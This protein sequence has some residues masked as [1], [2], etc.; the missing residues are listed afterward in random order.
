MLMKLTKLSMAYP[1]HVIAYAVL[2]T[3][4]FASQFVKIK[5]DTD[6][7]NMLPETSSVRVYNTKVEETFELHPDVIVLGMTHG[8]SIFNEKTLHRLA[9]LTEKIKTID[10]VIPEDIISLAEASNVY[11]EGGALV[12]RPA[13]SE[14]SPDENRLKRLRASVTQN[15]LFSGKLVSRDGKTTVIYIPIVRKASGKKITD[16]ITKL[17]PKN[18]EERFY[19]A[20]DPVAR[21]T[22]GEDMFKQMAFFSPL[23]G[24]VMFIM[25]WLMFKNFTLIIVNMGVA[26]IS[27][28]WSMG[29]FI[30]AGV[31]VHIMSSM[32]PVFLMAI[33]TDTVHIFNEFYF[34]LRETKNKE[35][36]VLKTMEAVARPILFTDLT[37]MAGF[38]SLATGH[39]VP[40]KIFGLMI[41]AGTFVILL[42]SFTIVPAV[43][44]LIPER[45]L[46]HPE[47]EAHTGSRFLERL[48]SFSFAQKKGIALVSVILFV[49]SVFGMSKLHVNNNMLAWFK[50]GSTVRVADDVMNKTLSGTAFGYVVA[51]A[52]KEG[53]IKNPRALKEIELLQRDI[54]KIPD[55]G[56]TLSIVD[57]LKRIHRVLHGD[58]SAYEKIPDAQNIIA[59]YLFLFSMSAK[60]RDVNN[61]LEPSYREAAIFVQLETW[62]AD[63]YEKVVEKLKEHSGKN[64]STLSYK[65][66]GIAYFNMIWNKE[67]LYGMLHGFIMG[68]LF[69]FVLMA[70]SFRSVFWGAAASVPL[71]FTIALIYGFV[72]FVGKDFDMPI[73][74]LSTLSLG[75]ATDFAVHFVGRFQQKVNEGA[76]VKDALLWTVKRPG[77]GIVRNAI[78][79]SSGFLVMVFSPLTP[80]ITVG[81]FMA[82]IMLI[83]ALATLV[84]LPG[85][86]A[87]TQSAWNKKKM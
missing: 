41:A 20:G 85:I 34:R 28:I 63:A 54:E 64:A 5:T 72:G 50:K 59:Q 11:E 62:D 19:I 36:A 83:S 74:V 38:A 35:E 55:V 9:E 75:L 84:L 77:A 25:L 70:L 30:G 10:G 4:L 22:F 14:I 71:L 23:A 6:P 65:P 66:A 31:P 53:G 51:S 29:A 79:F 17:L 61:F 47:S 49:I 3:L 48:G 60:P 26:I 73:S 21:D 2:L 7:K 76:A 82:A 81:V 68:T 13:V 37:T 56:K 52:P 12:V 32:S 80:Y 86:V 18:S 57:V 58:K 67:V 1:R 39:I 46:P 16:E 42:S 40:V 78:L 33:A 15:P 44:S 69:V 43:L 45:A 24:M 87:F 8:K 27:I